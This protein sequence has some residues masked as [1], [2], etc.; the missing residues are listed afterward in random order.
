METPKLHSKYINF[1]KDVNKVDHQLSY[2]KYAISAL[3]KK[4]IADSITKIFKIPMNDH[5]LSFSVSFENAL[6]L[7]TKILTE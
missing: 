1:L 6:N 2:I 3:E 4:Q 7:R 5:T